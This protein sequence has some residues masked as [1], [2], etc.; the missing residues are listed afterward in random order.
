MSIICEIKH[1]GKIIAKHI[2]ADL[3]GEGLSFFSDDQ[4]FL[5]VGTWSYKSGKQLAKHIH[6]DVERS[7][8][9]THEVLFVRQ[10]SLR[11][12]I[13]NLNQE[14]V[15]NIILSAGDVL[16]L[17]DCGHGYEILED[18]TKVLEIKNGPYLGADIDRRRF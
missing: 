4:D 13:Y 14:E 16:I 18:N 7:V 5:Q 6:N 9:R 3:W 8:N 17:M 10:G 12:T 1:E 11:A 2:P 15:G